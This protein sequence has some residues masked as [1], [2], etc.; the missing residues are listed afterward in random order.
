MD[1]KKRFIP[2]TVKV[3]FGGRT[4]SQQTKSQ[5]FNSAGV[6]HYITIDKIQKKATINFC[7]SL[8]IK[9]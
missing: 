4:E 6:L 5:Q 9:K 8:T 3:P 7:I 2:V 1:L